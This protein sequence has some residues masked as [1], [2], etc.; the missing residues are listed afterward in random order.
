MYIWTL[1]CKEG[2]TFEL[3]KLAEKALIS[4]TFNPL[5][6]DL[7]SCKRKDNSMIYASM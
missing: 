6:Q 5:H 3:G 1:L 2:T 4:Q 7:Y